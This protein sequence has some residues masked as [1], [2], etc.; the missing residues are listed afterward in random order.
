MWW[1]CGFSGV[2]L[3]SQKEEAVAYN[4]LFFIGSDNLKANY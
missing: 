1:V 2:V 4:R 3:L